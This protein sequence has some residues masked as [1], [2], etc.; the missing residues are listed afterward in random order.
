MRTGKVLGERQYSS[1][2]GD[3]NSKGDY[4]RLRDRAPI[5]RFYKVIKHARF[6]FLMIVPV[7]VVASVLL[8]TQHDNTEYVLSAIKA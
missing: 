7:V 8:L 4:M 2:G 6:Q 5:R 1:L 3:D